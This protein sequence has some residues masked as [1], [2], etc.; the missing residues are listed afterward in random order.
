MGDA[1]RAS[2]RVLIVEDDA[3]LRE[4]LRRAVRDMDFRVEVA[5]SAEEALELMVAKEFDVALTDLRL[6]RLSGL[7]LCRIA[8]ERWPTTQMVILTGHGDLEAARRAI[9]LD[10]VDFLVKPAPLADIEGALERAMRR[11]RASIVSR[12]APPDMQGDPGAAP[13]ADG[14]AQASVE[15]PRRLRDLEREHILD[16]LARHDGNRSATADELGISVRT[17]YYRLAEY[18]SQGFYLREGDG[19]T[20]G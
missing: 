17:L 12:E 10:V 14:G 1:S 9:H 5:A 20:K 16:A 11:R 7:D 2:N 19:P 13:D 6:P 3:K 4:M 8:R 18:E 15:T